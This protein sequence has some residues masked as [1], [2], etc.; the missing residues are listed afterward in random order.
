MTQL[1]ALICGTLFG[2]GLAISGMTDTHKVQGFLDL[3]GAWD[4]ALVFVMGGAV[5]TTFIGFHFVQ[6]LSKPSFAASFSLPTNNRIDKPLLIGAA[7]F[8]IGWGLY[9]YCP[10]PAISSLAYLRPESL[11]FVIAMVTGMWVEKLW[12]ERSI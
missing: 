3:F 11:V 12:R 2:L 8:G 5:V 6:K 9:G 10:G 4:P 7:I 1:I